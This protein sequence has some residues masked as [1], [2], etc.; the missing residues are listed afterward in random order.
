MSFLLFTVNVSAEILKKIEV[1]GNKRISK[2]TIRVYG[3]IQINQ[4]YKDDDINAVIK[5]LYDT[6]FFSTISTSFSNGILQIT[7]KELSLINI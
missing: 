4:N 3:D 1:T 5:K 2:E 7:V 6:N